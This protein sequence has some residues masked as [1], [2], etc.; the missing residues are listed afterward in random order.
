MDRSGDARVC[1]TCGRAIFAPQAARKD[2]AGRWM[3]VV[4]PSDSEYADQRRADEAA[5]ENAM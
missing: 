1:G 4:C 5:S 2:P 3:H